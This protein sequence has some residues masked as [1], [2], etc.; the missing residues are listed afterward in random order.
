MKILIYA[1][2][3]FSHDITWGF[4]QLGHEVKQIAPNSPAEAKDI[5]IAEAPDLL[6]TAG[7]PTYYNEDILEYLGSRPVK[8][9]KYIHWDTDGI[10]W[11]DI[12]MQ[13][14]NFLKPDMVFTVCPDMLAHLRKQDILCAMLPYAFCPESHYPGPIEPEHTGRIAFVAG[15]YGIVLEQFPQHYRRISMDVLIKPLLDN[16]CRVDFYGDIYH[17]DVIKSLYN[18]NVPLEWVHPRMPYSETWQVYNSCAINLVTQNHEHTITKRTFEILG[19]GGFALS[20]ANTAVQEFFKPGIDLEIS[21]SPEETTEKVAYYLK[22]TQAY[23]KIRQNAI[24]S[25]QHH[26]YKQRA[27]L[28]MDWYAKL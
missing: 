16:Y 20:Y 9:V 26:T 28:V 6:F 1:D 17:K 3:Y 8:E 27:Q 5:M 10:T 21:S 19:S 15:A 7:S 14:I 13:H 18:F 2:S 11:L 25:V 22:N 24:K 12:E 4:A 23:N